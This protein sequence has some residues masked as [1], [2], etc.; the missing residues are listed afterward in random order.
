MPPPNGPATTSDAPCVRR[1]PN[2]HRSRGQRW[3]GAV[4]GLITLQREYSAWLQAL[5]DSLQESATAEAL[6]PY[7]TWTLAIS[8]TV[9]RRETGRG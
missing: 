6:Q 1:S 4:A 9:V 3:R 5:L 2:N 7:A 8:F